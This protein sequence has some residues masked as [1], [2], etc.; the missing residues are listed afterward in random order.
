[1][2]IPT[3]S[4][5]IPHLTTEQMI[6]VDR[7]MIEEYGI[8]LIQMMENAGRCLAILARERFD[9]PAHI[10]VLA[11]TGGNGGG[12]MV[13][14]R[15][16]AAWGH[17][18]KVFTTKGPDRMTEIPRHQHDILLQMGVEVTYES[19]PPN[20]WSTELILDGIIGYSVQGD[21]Y[22]V[23]GAMIDWANRNIAPV[24]S[25]DTPSG[26]DLTSGVAFSPTI[27]ATATLTLALPKQGLFS[28]Q[29]LP[30][31]GEL[32]LGDISVPPG[33]YQAPSLSLSVSPEVFREGDVVGIQ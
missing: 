3:S 27:Q 9:H 4:D 14:A 15:R 31:V 7:L 28:A 11:G 22:G 16:L 1:M 12:A 13:A 33:L 29:G 8:L 24:V 5:P 23:P 20:D 32:Y 26:L 30:R 10:T 2:P 17:N 21:P 19:A 18:V 25:L 6:E